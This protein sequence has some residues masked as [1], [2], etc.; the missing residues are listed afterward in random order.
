MNP[1][2]KNLILLLCL[3]STLLPSFT[4]NAAQLTHSAARQIQQAYQLQ[5]KEQYAKAITLLKEINTSNQYDQAYINRMLGWLYWQQKQPTRAIQALIKAVDAKILSQDEALS[6]RRMLA[7]L[8]LSEGK[9]QSAESYYLSLL[10]EYQD[11]ITL[12]QLW[13]RVAQTQYQQQKWPQVETSIGKL[14]KYQKQVQVTPL[15]MLL[16]AQLQ[17][18]K[19]LKAISTT[20]LIRNIEPTNIIWWQQLSNL[21]LYIN[22]TKNALITLQQADRAGLKLSQQEKELMANLYAQAD[23]PFNAATLYQNFD[24]LTVSEAQL[25]RQAIYW[26]SAKEWDKAIVTWTK[27]TKF[28]TKYYWQIAVSNLQLNRYQATLDAL[29]QLPN[30]TNQ[31]LLLEVQALN[32]LGK[33]DLALA[34]AQQA[35]KQQPTSSSLNWIKYLSSK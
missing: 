16:T 13:L 5:N 2:Q 11:S 21:Y 7:D 1:I 24:S 25:Q 14:L 22:D 34:T 12:S 15:N 28:N 29:K 8:L 18:K 30:K 31:M 35:H 9:Y 33:T 27:A 3:A 26:Q 17:Q 10:K 20:R 32:E 23:V 19:W 4:L 6:S